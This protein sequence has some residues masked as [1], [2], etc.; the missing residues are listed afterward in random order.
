[1]AWSLGVRDRERD[2]APERPLGLMTS[3]D[4]IRALVHWLRYF[5][6]DQSGGSSPPPMH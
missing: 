6:D 4:P 5:R 3:L 1:M 2:V